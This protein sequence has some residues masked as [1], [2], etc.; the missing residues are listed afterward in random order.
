MAS[1]K[2]G[3]LKK[4]KKWFGKCRVE[5]I[6]LQSCCEAG[7]KMD[8]RRPNVLKKK[9]KLRT[10]GRPRNPGAAG[11]RSPEECRPERKGVLAD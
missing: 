8:F 3:G 9:N 2:L 4:I 10:D 1:E 7:S 11:N 6:T 5:P